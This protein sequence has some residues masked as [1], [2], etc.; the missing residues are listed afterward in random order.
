MLPFNVAG[1]RKQVWICPC[2]GVK[3]QVLVSF[4]PAQSGATWGTCSREHQEGAEPQPLPAT[5]QA[6][7]QG[8]ISASNDVKHRIMIRGAVKL[9]ESLKKLFCYFRT[10]SP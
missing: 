6:A 9:K 3:E 4:I 10:A 2:T 1:F 8:L 7:L 5:G